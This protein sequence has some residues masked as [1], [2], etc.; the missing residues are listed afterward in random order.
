VALTERE[1][2]FRS[3]TASVGMITLGGDGVAEAVRVG[4]CLLD[5]ALRSTGTE[6]RGRT[7]RLG[8]D[9]R[10]ALRR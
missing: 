10:C 2:E 9:P 8:Q 3:R 5:G 7:G 4:V 6:G 1:L